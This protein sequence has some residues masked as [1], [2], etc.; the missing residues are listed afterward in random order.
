MKEVIETNA[1]RLAFIGDITKIKQI[2]VAGLSSCIVSA[3]KRD[4]D[5]VAH[6]LDAFGCNRP[7]GCYNTWEGVPRDFEN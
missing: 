3:C 7:S 2:I 1:Y 5:R 6:A 4:S